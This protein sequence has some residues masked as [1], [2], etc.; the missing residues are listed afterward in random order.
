MTEAEL[1]LA[2]SLALAEVH[3]LRTQPTAAVVVQPAPTGE[4]LA[5]CHQAFVMLLAAASH[6]DRRAPRVAEELRT[7]AHLLQ[8]A[9]KAPA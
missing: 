8:L 3:R 2:L 5:E 1:C 4:L 9:M 6:L 7:R